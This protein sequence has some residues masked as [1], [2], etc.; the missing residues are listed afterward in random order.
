VVTDCHTTAGSAGGS[1]GH[2]LDDR[3]A[4]RVAGE[5]AARDV[6]GDREAA[7]LRATAGP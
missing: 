1:S 2:G 6:A 3:P 4:G 7:G 5:L